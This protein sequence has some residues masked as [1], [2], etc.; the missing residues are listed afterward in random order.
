MQVD[1]TITYTRKLLSEIQINTR[2]F[3]KEFLY[4]IILQLLLYVCEK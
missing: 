3:A 1:Y 2:F 4:M